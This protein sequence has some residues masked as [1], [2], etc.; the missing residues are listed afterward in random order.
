[1]NALF[2]LLEP[3]EL[4]TYEFT[5]KCGEWQG[6]SRYEKQNLTIKV[7]LPYLVDSPNKESTIKQTSGPQPDRYFLSAHSFLCNADQGI[8]VSDK[9]SQNL[10]NFFFSLQLVYSF[11]NPE[12][13]TTRASSQKF[14]QL[15]FTPD[16]LGQGR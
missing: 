5:Q 1:M 14:D 11:F 3:E 9:L 10:P 8:D 12:P 4:H 2:T 15:S 13:F 6:S 16:V 7:S